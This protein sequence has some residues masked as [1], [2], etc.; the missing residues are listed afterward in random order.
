MVA[1]D[2]G[3]GR[4][5]WRA[6]ED[7]PGYSSPVMVTVGSTEQLLV[8]TADRLVALDPRTG[9]EIWQA[10]FRTSSYDVA[11]ISPVSDGSRVFVSGYWDGASA[12]R[13]ERGSRS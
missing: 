6:L 2:R 13:L 11:I 8:W 9:G 7:R 5:R 1:L 3:T 4:E 12:W 10:S